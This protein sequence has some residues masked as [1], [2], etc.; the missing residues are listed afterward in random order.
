MTQTKP[1]MFSIFRSR[2]FTLLWIGQLISAMGSSLTLLAAS[3]LVFRQTGSTLSVGLMLISTAG[4]TILVGLFAG[5]YVDRSDRKKVMLA[6]DI[7]R[8]VLILFI[9]ILIPLNI[10]WLYI[11]VALTSAI[12]QFFDSAHASVLPE[13]ASDDELSAANALM[14]VS[15]VGSTMFG[16]AA[17]GIIV[18]KLSVEWA[19]YIDGFSFF[20]SA[21]MILSTRL[22]QLPIIKNTSLKAVIDNLKEGARVVRDFDVLRSLFLV[23]GPIFLLFGLQNT[24]LLPFALTELNATEFE[25]GLQQAADAI[26]VAVGSL[27]MARYAD[28]IREGQWLVISYVLMAAGCIWYALTTHISIVILLTGYIGFANVFFFI[29]RQFLIQCAT[30]REMRGRVNSAFFVLRD[31]TFVIGMALAGLADYWDVRL[32][33]LYSSFAILITGL[34][35]QFLPGLGQPASQWKRTVALLRGTEAAPRLG[36]GR[37]ATRSEVDR[38]IEKM[39]ELG[40]MTERERGKLVAETLV[41]SAKP[42]KVVIYRGEISDSAY[43]ILKGSVG[44]GYLTE[45]EYVILSYLQAGDF[46][47][48]VAALT[49]SQRTANIITEEE[50]EFLIIPARTMKR[51]ATKYDRLRET[52]YTTISERLGR[53]ELPRN[54]SQDQALLRDL[55]TSHSDAKPVKP[56]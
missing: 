31:V 39:P 45:T 14:S 9:P 6:A 1:T 55:R 17:A 13:V 4:P 10:I 35:V 52:F 43:F 53:I 47:G 22:P 41:A 30:P 24:L 40:Q 2:T 38:F 15:S 56:T 51:L 37:P 32:L 26:G 34:V 27:L 36:A 21:I 49:G 3:I 42:G 50:C 20:L 19:F 5:V 54:V 28:R 23:A 16:F 8:G 44:A 12:S 29:G 18:Q 48:E 11:I 46:F 33:L 7:A 25:Y